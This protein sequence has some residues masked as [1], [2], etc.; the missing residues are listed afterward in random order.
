MSSARENILVYLVA[1]IQAI[2]GLTVFRSREAA[3]SRSE[4]AVLILKPLEEQVVKIAGEIAVRDLHVTLTLIVRGVVPDSIADPYLVQITAL[5]QDDTTLGGLAARCIEKT[6]RWDMHIADLTALIVELTFVIKY[7]TPTG[8][9][10][11][12]A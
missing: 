12:L 5:I 7:L 1:Q 10:G 8:T 2:T 4:G 6:T 9:I 11:A 3:V